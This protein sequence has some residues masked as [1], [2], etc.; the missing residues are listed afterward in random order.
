MAAARPALRM[1]QYRR[2]SAMLALIVEIG[3]RSELP[4]ERSRMWA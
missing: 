1:G 4:V 3:S 2:G